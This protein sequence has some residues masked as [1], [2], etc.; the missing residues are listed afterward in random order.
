MPL[1][2]RLFSGVLKLQL[3]H[4]AP[5]ERFRSRKDAGVSNRVKNSL[6][7]LNRVF[8]SELK[9]ES[10]QKLTCISLVQFT[11]AFA[12]GFCRFS[13]YFEFLWIE[14]SFDCKWHKPLINS[15]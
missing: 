9:V 3:S 11:N 12:V 14:A 2:H 13:S 1:V 15:K 4:G 6:T 5:S 7:S 8:S 10:L